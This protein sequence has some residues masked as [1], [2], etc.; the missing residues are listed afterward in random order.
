MPYINTTALVWNHKLLS[1]IKVLNIIGPG[2]QKTLAAH[3]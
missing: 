2:R 3:P 1:L